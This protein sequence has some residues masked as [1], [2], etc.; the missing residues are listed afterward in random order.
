MQNIKRG[1]NFVRAWGQ[2]GQSRGVSRAGALIAL[3]IQEG[4]NATGVVFAAGVGSKGG[5]DK[6]RL[7]SARRVPG[8]S[9]GEVGDSGGW[10]AWMEDGCSVIDYTI[11][12]PPP[13]FFF[14]S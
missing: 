13:F 1:N 4:G 14:F 2:F 12:I 5:G 9:L 6:A 3:L 11:C 7:S 10:A 8:G